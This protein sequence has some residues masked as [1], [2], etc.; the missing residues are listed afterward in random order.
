[1]THAELYSTSAPSASPAP[2]KSTRKRVF[3]VVAL[4]SSLGIASAAFSAA[5]PASAAPS[6]ADAQA[7]AKSI[8]ASIAAANA[9]IQTL[10]GQVQ[11]S[12][13]KLDQL[14]SQIAAS[15]AQIAKDQ[16]V[17][18]TDQTQLRGQA[19]TDYTNSGTTDQ[20]TQMFSSDPNTSGIRSEYSSIATGNV[21]TTIDKLHTAQSQLQANQA[22]L[23]QQQSSATTTRNSEQAAESQANAL[24][25]QDQASLNSVNATIQADIAAQQAA[26]AAAAKAAAA[27]A[28]NARV[29]ASQKAQAAAAAATHTTSGG[30]GSSSG[31]G[32]APA[33]P[34]GPPPP[35]PQNAAG[36]I[37]AAQ[38]QLNVPYVWGGESPGS[39]F[40]CSGLVQWAWAQAGVSLPRTS[41]AQF[42]ATTQVPLA[43]IQPGDLLFYG[44]DG[45]EHVAMYIGG[46]T[47]V[48]AP[49]TGETVHDT[50]VRTGGDF[51]GVGRVG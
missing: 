18:D 40:D 28:F 50:G 2:R 45:S 42:E 12:D 17:V 23:Q 41:G 10:T 5:R 15:Q 16:A 9:Q 14:N 26:A 3:A 47:M 51:A 48:E 29:A 19:I 33:A 49:Q 39:G 20:M 27:A 32:H 38:S 13:F 35:V 8:T 4:A 6:L 1:M 11:A 7:Q 21:T 30:G 37:Q 43:D 25:A 31:G 24:A 36:A 22:S 44:P 46:G 34:T